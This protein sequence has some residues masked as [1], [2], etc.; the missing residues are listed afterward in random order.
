MP[1]ADA[2]FA[3]SIPALYD[4]CLGPMLFEPF[5]EDM[6]GRAATFRPKMILETAAG[7]GILT[8]RLAAFMPHAGITATDLNPDMLM[9]ARREKDHEPQVR[10]ERADA[11]GLPFLDES[12]DLVVCQFGVM[13]YPDRVQAHRETRRVLRPEGTYLFS[14]WDG[15]DANPVSKCVAAAV[16]RIFPDNPPSFLNRVPFGYSDWAQIEADLHAGG[17]DQVG[18]ET[19]AKTSRTTAE[20]AA[21][22]LCCG[23]PL[24]AEIEARAPGRVEEVAGA[25]AEDLRALWGAGAVEQPMSALAI[26]AR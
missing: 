24:R 12:F 17:F 3:G 6:A 25:V 10:Y 7:T 22:G 5:A 23:S 13:F 4:R 1:S 15:I 11:L 18:I 21:T 20:D 26:L 9:L 16:T 8:E 14:V 19:V 2:A